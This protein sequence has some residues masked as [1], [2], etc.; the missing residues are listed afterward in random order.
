MVLPYIKMNLPQVYTCSHAK[1][2]SH[3]PPRTIP[4]GHPSAPAPSILYPASNLD[5][6]F[7][8]YKMSRSCSIMTVQ[9]L[10][11][12]QLLRPHGLQHTRFPCPSPAPRA[13]SSSCPL[14]RWCHPTI[15]FS[16][17][18]FSSRLQSFPALGSFSVNQSF[19]SGGQSIGV[20][21]SASVLPMNTQHW[22]PSGLVGSIS[23]P[24]KGLSRVFTNTA[25]QKHQFFSAQL[26]LWSNSHIHTWLLEKP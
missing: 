23:L 8:S 4:L 21:A 12:V 20:S 25:V 26:S 1:P 9:S 15:S 22:F 17:I 5:W 10:S 19:S 11:C 18:P 3:F 2:S 24:C 16:V 6:L 14:S 7:I 13:Y